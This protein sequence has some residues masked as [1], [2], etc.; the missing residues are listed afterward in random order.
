MR[1]F[2]KSISRGLTLSLM[3]CS[4]AA[5]GSSVS[6]S[7]NSD[8]QRKTTEVV[9]DEATTEE[10]TEATTEAT[11][12]KD[13]E[14]ETTEKND[15][16]E[17]S[18]DDTDKIVKAYA[19]VLN[20]MY[21][22]VQDG[23]D[24]SRE[25]KY[26]STGI[27]EEASYG[28]S[29]SLGYILM[30]LNG[31]SSPELLIGKNGSSDGSETD[32]AAF[33]YA[34]YTL[35]DGTPLTIIEGWSRNSYYWIGDNHFYYTGSG[36]AMYSAFGECYL[37]GD[38]DALV[39]DD[40]YFTD[41]KDGSE[42]EEAFFH[43]NSG[44]WEPSESEELSIS[45]D[46]FWA[47]SEAYE[48]KVLDWIPLSDYTPVE[49]SDTSSEDQNTESEVTAVWADDVVDESTGYIGIEI[50]DPSEYTT[51]VLFSAKNEVKNFRI[52]ELSVKNIDNDGNIEF[53]YEERYSLD[54]LTTDLPVCAGLVFPGDTPSNGFMYTDNDG[55]D[56][57]F[58]LDVSGKDGSLYIW[59][60]EL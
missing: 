26:M 28:N 48:T 36:G 35:S 57:L 41:T 43:N 39:W 37:N 24:D 53:L 47:K 55:N 33:I 1:K 3:M 56:H 12:E 22:L 2:Y 27:M 11:T 25:Y 52:V 49:V 40:F 23:Y 51:H 18:S 45:S 5:C 21:S 34:G 31:D 17:S 15:E 30:D 8:S 32:D 59:E 54:T 50:A 16:T 29:D 46:D 44:E 60:Y 20:E 19:P 10:E 42:T 6:V 13:T 38:G 7:D 14:E 58:V 4:L 9:T